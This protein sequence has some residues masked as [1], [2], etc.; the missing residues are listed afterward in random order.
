MRDEAVRVV[1]SVREPRTWTETR[2]G[3]TR[4]RRHGAGKKAGTNEE[5]RDLAPT[6]GTL[7]QAL[8]SMQR[9]EDCHV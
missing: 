4:Q 9:M 2:G 1:Y 8:V 6:G 3:E 5:S 7:A